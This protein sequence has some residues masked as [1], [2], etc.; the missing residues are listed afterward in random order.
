VGR[1]TPCPPVYPA[2]R[3][4]RR[5]LTLLFGRTR[6]LPPRVV[7]SDDARGGRAN[8]A[9]GESFPAVSSAGA[10]S[11]H[12][13]AFGA[14][15]AGGAWAT[16]AAALLDVARER[17]SGSARR[18][19]WVGGARVVCPMPGCGE[20][21]AGGVACPGLFA[22]LHR[23]HSLQEVP[24]AVV[25]AYHLEGCRWGSRPFC[26]AAGRRRCLDLSYHKPHCPL[27]SHHRWGR[28]TAEAAAR[29]EVRGVAFSAGGAS[30]PCAAGGRRLFDADPP[31]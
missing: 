12:H 16:P 19:L 5:S 21:L 3:P 9:A 20:V 13:P 18:V 4:P 25:A 6:L 14:G 24:T 1:L 27:S 7:V 2:R 30:A 26:A 11:P 31:A 10:T 15:V 23:R 28:A 8:D 17:D 29:G 22:H